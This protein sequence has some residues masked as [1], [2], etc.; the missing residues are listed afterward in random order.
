MQKII[1]EMP[2]VYGGMQR[3]ER[4][5]DE[6]VGT[7]AGRDVYAVARGWTKKTMRKCIPFRWAWARVYVDD[8]VIEIRKDA[9]GK[10]TH[11]MMAVVK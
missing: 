1:V 10:F 4:T 5:V 8:Q 11:T 7:A 9:D 6:T 3:F 2:K